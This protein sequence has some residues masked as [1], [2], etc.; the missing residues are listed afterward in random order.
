L[1]HRK[2]E[3]R[4]SRSVGLL[5]SML[6]RYPEISSVKFDPRRRS[7]RLGILVMESLDA[8]PFAE[9]S[10]K[11]MEMLDVYNQLH[12]RT[13]VEL[14]IDQ[15]SLGALTV[16][17]LTRDIQTFSP[18]EIYV[19]IEFFRDRFTGR[20]VTEVGEPLGEDELIAQDEMIYDILT[21]LESSKSARNLI[22][23]REEGRVMVFQ[24]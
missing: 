10:L 11:L 14:A 20:L 22:A 7:I 2:Y 17:Y 19:L 8:A 5:F 4:F 18:E 6:V 12:H 23:I 21:D 16:I 1:G 15:E 3:D 24:K 9:L 13:P